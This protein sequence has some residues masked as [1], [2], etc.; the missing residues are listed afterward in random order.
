MRV[1][2]MKG[3]TSSALG[4]IVQLL[5]IL[6]FFLILIPAK[7]N[8]ATQALKKSKIKNKIKSKICYRPETP[9]A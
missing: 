9:D 2:K 6:L 1:L 3:S 4:A 8:A 5:L 7:W